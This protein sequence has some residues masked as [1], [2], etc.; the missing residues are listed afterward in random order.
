MKYSKLNGSG[1]LRRTVLG[2][3][4][5]DSNTWLPLRLKGTGADEVKIN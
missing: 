2:P 3:V 5:G 4:L 1:V